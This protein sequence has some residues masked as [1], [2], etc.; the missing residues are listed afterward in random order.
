MDRQ[1]I[2]QY[3]F[4]GH[5]QFDKLLD[6]AGGTLGLQTLMPD[7]IAVLRLPCNRPTHIGRKREKCL[8]PFLGHKG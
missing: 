8:R 5:N 4:F 6:V 2:A 1:A 7:E 3:A